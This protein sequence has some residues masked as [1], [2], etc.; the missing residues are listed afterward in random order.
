[1]IVFVINVAGKRKAMCRDDGGA[2]HMAGY[3]E[4]LNKSDFVVCLKVYQAE[5]ETIRE[6]SLPTY[7]TGR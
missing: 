2:A 4:L 1:M 6:A 3:F 5:S 7:T